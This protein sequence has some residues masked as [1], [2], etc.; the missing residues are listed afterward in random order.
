M[1]QGPQEAALFL[2]FLSFTGASQVPHRG[3]Q[4]R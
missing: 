1:L 2:P 4:L 3:W